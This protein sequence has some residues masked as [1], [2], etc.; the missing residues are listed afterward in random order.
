MLPCQVV[1]PLQVA[2]SGQTATSNLLYSPMA[3]PLYSFLVLYNRAVWGV[4]I[5]VSMLVANVIPMWEVKVSGV[6]EQ[7]ERVEV[8]HQAV[9]NI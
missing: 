7:V 2:M 3:L 9:L 1:D 4:V 5:V 6:L 8:V